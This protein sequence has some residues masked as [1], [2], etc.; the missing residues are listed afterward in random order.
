[1]HASGDAECNIFGCA[2]IGLGRIGTPSLLG[3]FYGSLLVGY[4]A[5]TV[6]FEYL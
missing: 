5:S 6:V 3:W 1:M 2:A 4:Y